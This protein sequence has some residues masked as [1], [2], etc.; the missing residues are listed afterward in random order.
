[1]ETCS[2]PCS[3]IVILLIIILCL[4]LCIWIPFGLIFGDNTYVIDPSARELDERTT[5]TP[6]VIRPTPY[7]QSEEPVLPGQGESGAAQ[8]RVLSLA[9]FETITTLD[10]IYVPGAHLRDLA[11]RLRGVEDIPQTYVHQDG[12]YQVGDTKNFW[13]TNIDS[14]QKFQVAATARYETENLLFWIEEGVRFNQ[15]DLGSLAETFQNEIYPTTRYFFGSESKPGIDEDPRIY[16]L[17]AGNLGS[18]TAGYFSSG[19]SQH[20]D[21]IPFSNGHDMFLL[22]SDHYSLRDPYLY[23]VLAHEFQHM[24]HANQDFNETAW[25][26][27]GLSELAVY[28]NGYYSGHFARAYAQNPGTQLND[29]PDSSESARSHY[30][31]SFLFT[32]YFFDRFG[33]DALRALVSEQENGLKSIDRVLQQFEFYETESEYPMTADDVFADWVIANYIQDPG[34]GDG[35]FTYS[36]LPDA[37][38]PAYRERIRNCPTELMTRD[39]RQYAVDYIRITCPGDYTLVFEGSTEVRVLPVEPNSGSYYFWSNRGDMSNMTLTR[40]FDFSDI[41]GPLTLSYW[42]WFDI[43]QDYDYLY[44]L[45]SLDGESWQILETPSGRMPDTLSNSYGWS[46]SG[47][48]GMT[49]PEWI[50][51]TVDLSSYAGQEVWLRFKYLTD[52]AVNGEGFLLDDIEIP[53]IDYYSGFEEDDGGWEAE[54]FVRIQNVLPQTFRISMIHKGQEINVEQIALSGM[55]ELEL[56]IRIGTEFDE[57]ILVVSGSTRHTRQ[58]AAYQFQ[59]HP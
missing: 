3:I 16:V 43:E 49:G 14:R 26:N 47:A 39:V 37:P 4:C 18:R 30:G 21:L 59:I 56:N 13:V 2:V 53:E 5:P 25:L 23:G 46:Y 1:L 41:E 52:D 45:A 38:R 17:F 42:T 15:N 55:N 10:E 6:V 50:N 9:A 7:Y 34:T 51:E 58:P 8:A 19:D 35:R 48:S 20:P 29:W 44:L 31:A 27:E 12:P 54:G 36:E 32:K 28:L 40:S 24:I 22:N 11:S 33:E 57:V